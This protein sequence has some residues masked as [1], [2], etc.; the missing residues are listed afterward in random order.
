MRAEIIPGGTLLR[1]LPLY[2]WMSVQTTP[3]AEHPNDPALG[4]P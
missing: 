3:L 1:S 2:A 4:A